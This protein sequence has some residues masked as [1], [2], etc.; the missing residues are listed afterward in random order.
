MHTEAPAP[1]ERGHTRPWK[2]IPRQVC[3]RQTRLYRA[4]GREEVQTV[5]TR[6]RWVRH[7]WSAQRLAVRK[8]T[9]DHPGKKTPGGEGST[10]FTPPPRLPLARPVTLEGTAAPVR[11]VWRPTPSPPERR[12][13]GMPTRQ[14]RAGQAGGNSARDPAGAARCAPHRSGCRPGRSGQE[15]LAAMCTAMGQTATD[16]LEADSETCV[17]RR[18]HAARRT[19][20]HPSPS[21]HRP[22][23]AGRTA[24]VLDQ[25]TVWPTHTGTR[26][27][28]T[29]SP[30]LAGLA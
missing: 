16:V 24:G 21:R 13:L 19:T 1:R 30:V 9:Q 3:T 4:A 7:A 22:R 15:A 28:G 12:P 5:R 20:V 6:Q 25:G 29:R 8:V 23:K 11:R 10:S 17:D 14:D 27:G 18:A 2:S 26:P